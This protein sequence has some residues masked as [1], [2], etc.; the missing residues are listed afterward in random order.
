MLPT[1][2]DVLALPEVR[3]G[4]PQVMTGTVGLDRGVRWV[5]VSELPDIAALLRG[6]ELILTTGIAL[7]DDDE[8]LRAYV[9]ELA[10]AGASGLVVELGRRYLSLPAALT[11]QASAAGVPLVALRAQVPF[12]AV[13]EAV[14]T[15]ILDAQHEQLRMSEAAHVAFT[16]LSV[17]G[18]SGQE[19]VERVAQ[20]SDHA[21]VL[22]D[23]S[24]CVLAYA[25]GRTPV[26]ELLHD[27]EARSRVV[28]DVD[29]PTSGSPDAPGAGDART[30]LTAAVGPRWQRWGRLVLPE[31]SGHLPQLRMLLERAAESLTLNRLAERH[32]AS[33]ERQASA[34][35][36]T[37]LVDGRAGP[38]GTVRTR[39]AALGLPVTNRSFVAVAVRAGPSS[40]SGPVGR[41]AHGRGLADC[42][43]RAA[44]SSGMRALVSTE[45]S[46]DVLVLI[47]LPAARE[48]HDELERFTAAVV[49]ELRGTGGDPEQHPVAAG[50]A[51]ATLTGAGGS[52]VEARHVAQVAGALARPTSRSYWVSAD[53]RLRGV[54]TVLRHEPR[55][56]AFAESELH[57]LL[58]HDATHGTDLVATLQAYLEAGGN[59]TRL[60]RESHVSRP[61]LYSRLAAVER[62]LGVRLDD[63]E[64]RLSL[65]VALL[66]RE[67]RSRSVPDSTQTGPGG[68]L[69]R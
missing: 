42:V 16:A 13:T 62:V 4:L 64:S 1:V 6:G 46:A 63:A 7:P 41:Q 31:P 66:V 20:M 53:L 55:L 47:A 65:H 51:V 32:Q 26:A 15:R 67:V 58:S 2:A 35:L 9:R 19:I 25:A 14:H 28:P 59:K 43:A 24:H 29:G 49:R 27:W 40:R 10:T 45:Q 8:G 33:L 11:G 61:A 44:A 50:A 21:V 60:A 12:I 56:L 5:H 48:V 18:A 54:L 17:D 23:L 3:R 34:G 36:I 68:Q 39:A 57:R 38:E 30:A 37:D 52:L 22:E 69:R